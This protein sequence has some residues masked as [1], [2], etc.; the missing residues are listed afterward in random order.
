MSSAKPKPTFY[1]AVFVIIVGLVGLALWR[2]G[3]RYVHLLSA[4]D[5]VP[6][7]PGS[8]RLL[9]ADGAEVQSSAQPIAGAV[10]LSIRQAADG[11]RRVHLV[12]LRAQE[13]ADWDGVR[14]PT[15]PSRGL[16]L[17]WPTAGDLVA[18]SPWTRGGDAG[19]LQP[20]AGHPGWWQLPDFDRWLMVVP[21]RT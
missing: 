17:E 21:S 13:S 15:P 2:F 9:D 1:L 16:R 10:W 8:V 5:L 11:Q 12:D 19:R 7:D 20:A 14:Q 3:A 4:L 6:E 18:A